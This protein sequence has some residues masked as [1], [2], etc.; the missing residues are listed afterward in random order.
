MLRQRNDTHAVDVAWIG[1]LF[2]V[3]HQSVKCLARLPRPL[4]LR[5]PQ[6]SSED[7]ARLGPLWYEGC[8]ASL[9][10]AEAWQ[11]PQI[12]CIQTMVFVLE[13]AARNRQ[14]T[15]LIASYCLVLV[16]SPLLHVMKVHPWSSRRSGGLLRRAS[17][18]C[19]V[20]I[21]LVPIPT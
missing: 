5:L 3:L 16:P 21:S 15:L 13:L 20:L 4:P 7:C 6:V 8:K 18:G 11:R 19:L 1:L 12:R 9:Y 10:L 17:L 2:S 14:L